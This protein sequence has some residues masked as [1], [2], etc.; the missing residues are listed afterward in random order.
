M[1]DQPEY[2]S[3]GSVEVRIDA[4]REEKPNGWGHPFFQVMA[5]EIYSANVTPH[6]FPP[7]WTVEDHNDACL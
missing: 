5:I 1:L 3:Q 6:R 4:C 7:P 2:S